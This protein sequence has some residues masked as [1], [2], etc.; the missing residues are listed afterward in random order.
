MIYLTND[1]N[2]DTLKISTVPCLFVMGQ[3]NINYKRSG[4]TN[5]ACALWIDPH[6][7]DSI[8]SQKPLVS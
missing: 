2:L 3:K 1:A 8:E 4:Q 7:G 5:L 6:D